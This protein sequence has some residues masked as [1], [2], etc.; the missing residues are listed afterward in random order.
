MSSENDDPKRLGDWQLDQLRFSAE[1]RDI[2]DVASKDLLALCDEAAASRRTRRHP[3]AALWVLAPAA[4]IVQ[5]IWTGD[6]RWLATGFVCLF[7]V[8]AIGAAL[9]SRRRVEPPTVDIHRADGKWIKGLPWTPNIDKLW[10]TET[11]LETKVLEWLRKHHDGAQFEVTGVES[12]RPFGTDWGGPDEHTPTFY[13]DVAY[14]TTDPSRP[15]LHLTAEGSVMESL[16]RH[17][18]GGEE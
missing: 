2:V 15:T 12:V 5:W 13:V 3:F 10:L 17:V 16:W 11:S 6:W 18:I 4:G 9:D 7:V 1:Q 14:T 8:G